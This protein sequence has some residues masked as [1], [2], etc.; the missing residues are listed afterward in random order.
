M[1]TYV[2][3][4]I[5]GRVIHNFIYNINELVLYQTSLKLHVNYF[6]TN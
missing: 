2:F 6:L 3:S 4:V 5:I 1:K